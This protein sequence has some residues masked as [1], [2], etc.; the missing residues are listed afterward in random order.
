VAQAMLAKEPVFKEFRLRMEVL[1][2]QNKLLLTLV[3]W[4]V[5]KQGGNIWMAQENMASTSQAPLPRI[6][7]EGS[8]KTCSQPPLTCQT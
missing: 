5:K 4:L 7:D 3:S 1:E 8:L 6:I 2:K